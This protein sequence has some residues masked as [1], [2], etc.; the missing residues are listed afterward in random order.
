MNPNA[1]LPP[2]PSGHPVIGHTLDFARSPFEFV[3]RATNECGDL[4]R[5]ELPS[6]DVYVLAH[7]EYFKQALV[8]DIDAFGKT[9]DFQRV[10]GNGLLSTE[11]EQW[12]RQRGILQPLFH[13]DRIGGYGEYMVDATQRRLATWKPGETRN[14]ESEMQDLTIEIL[15]ATLFGRELPPGEG[16]ELRAASDGLNKWF[17]PTSWLLP[18]WI[19]TPSRREFG[20]SV[21]RLRTEVRQLL[22]EYSADS[23]QE[24][25][26]QPNDLQQ[27]TLLSKLHDAREASGPDHLSTEE[28]EDQMLTMIFAG[29]ETT[30]AALGFAWYS[31]AMNPEIRQ[32][33]HD[34]LDAVLGDEPPTPEDIANLDLTNRIVTETLRLYPPIHTIPRQTTRDVQIDGYQIPANE[35]VHLSIIST[36]RDE[37]F[38]DDPLSFRPDRWTENFE[39][40]LDD[41]AFIPFGG[42]RRTCI[43]REFARLEATLVLAT[44]GQQWTLE[45]AGADP[46]ITI[47]P[48]ITTQT[49]NGL[50]MRLRQR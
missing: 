43:G 50:P 1:R 49:K 6:V 15:F 20:N 31:L 27:E 18:N 7:P 47:E 38:Y 48:E 32:A 34:E 10:F 19:P 9:E 8:T 11:G 21:E 40:E 24:V 36:H 5:M 41:H 14:I 29:Y 33:F 2:A 39:E 13:R 25:S 46:T 22:A 26:S 12:S 37:R 42:G 16:D 35:E 45:W 23:E 17:A 28:V 30:A 4:Y 44:I 3:D